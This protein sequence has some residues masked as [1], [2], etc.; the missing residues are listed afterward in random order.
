[1]NVTTS[2]S[3]AL[4]T[5]TAAAVTLTACSSTGESTSG[6]ESSVPHGY[7]E[8]AEETSDTQYRLVVGS[9]DD[10]G[11]AVIDLVTGATE[12]VGTAPGLRGI[13][14]DG[15]YG[16]AHTDSGT[17]HI[18][19]SGG[20]T[21]DH[22]D[23]V[24]Y[25][26]TTPRV[27]GTLDNPGPLRAVYGSAT[28]TVLTFEGS[29]VVLDRTEQD[30]GVVKVLDRLPTATAAAAIPLGDAMLIPTPT[31]ITVRST[32]SAQQRVPCPT[33]SG[34]AVTRRGAVYAC[35]DGAVLVT[36]TGTT[37]RIPH[38]AG[39]SGSATGFAHRSG[40][41]G[42]FA[43]GPGG[44][45]LLDV[46]ARSWTPLPAGVPERSTAAGENGPIISVDAGR[47]EVRRTPQA[48]PATTDLPGM[49]QAGT[50]VADT[51][52]A[53]VNDLR[54]NRIFEI[55]YR[56]DARLARTIPTPAVASYFVE[57]GR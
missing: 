44:P 30:R 56:D 39:T 15:R 51:S 32:A 21:V 34:Q 25:Y 24:H 17:T 37:T 36:D 9:A 35:A 6:E 18:V 49:G 45:Q 23:H 53:Y 38:P 46:T 26:R 29:T 41:A 28:R 11:L 13:V 12:E 4:L 43:S 48:P 57:T 5:V 20:W 22:D 3:I 50:V 14:G 19:D 42:L 27:V 2:R 7:V 8:G 33:P 40:S 47:V 55:D 1:M 52:R 10:A 54:N 16:Y 31:H